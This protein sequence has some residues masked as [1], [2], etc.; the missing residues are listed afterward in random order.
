MKK[1]ITALNLSEKK[2]E[3]K[4]ITA[5][6]AYD[7]FTARVLDEA[8]IDILLVGDSLA[9]VFMGEA[10]TFNVTVEQIAYHVKACSNAVNRAFL[11]AD[12]P[13]LSYNLSASET[14]VNAGKF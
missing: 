2:L 5:L 14:L 3:K 7:Y 12:M 13:F 1:K 10:N 8:G 9:H 11:V 6:T 4:K